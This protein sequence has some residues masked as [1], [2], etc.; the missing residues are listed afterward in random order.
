MS[1]CASMQGIGTGSCEAID[2]SNFVGAQVNPSMAKVVDRD[3]D[4]EFPERIL[5]QTSEINFSEF[6]SGR[7]P[8]LV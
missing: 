8:D 6:S 5:D 1:G 7:F 3:P 2:S 4:Q